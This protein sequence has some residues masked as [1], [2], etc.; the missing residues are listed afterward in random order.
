MENFYS[1]TKRATQQC[2]NYLSDLCGPKSPSL[3]PL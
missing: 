3:Y 2:N 1:T